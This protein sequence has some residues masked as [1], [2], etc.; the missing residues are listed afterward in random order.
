MVEGPVQRG[1]RAIK[2]NGLV[3]HVVV[4]CSLHLKRNV[5]PG[6]VV[7]KAWNTRCNPNPLLIVPNIPL[8]PVCDAALVTKN[9]SHVAEELINVEFQGLGQIEI[10]SVEVH[11]VGEI[12]ER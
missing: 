3:R 9:E 10:V 4:R 7:G 11:V 5:V 8:V 2:S 6:I 1:R 12:G